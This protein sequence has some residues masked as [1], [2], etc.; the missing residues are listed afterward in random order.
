MLSNN[1]LLTGDDGYNLTKSLRFRGSASAYLNRTPSASNRKTWTWSA[2]VK[3]GTSTFNTLFAAFQPAPR[4]YIAFYNN[5]IY[6][7]GT[8]AG[9]DF[10]ECS[11]TA[12]FRDFS[13]WYHIVFV[14]DTTQATGSNRV[15][16]Y[17]NGVQQTLTFTT[18]PSQN[19]DGAINGAWGHF[20]GAQ[21]SI[22]P[23]MDAYL[24][25]VNFIDG[26]ALTPSSFGE[27]D[28]LTGVWKPKKF[29]GTY[30]TNGFYLPFTDVAT[31]S[32]SNTGLGKDFSGNG[33]YFTTNNIS[34]T[35]GSTYD[36]MTDV[37][38]LTSATTANYCVINPLSPVNTSSIGSSTTVTQG[39]LYVDFA[40]TAYDGFMPA[41]MGTTS[42]KFYYEFKLNATTSSSHMIGIVGSTS[43]FGE[44]VVAVYR[45]ATGIVRV[46]ASTVTTG[47]A[48][49]TAGDVIGVA[50]DATNGTCAWYKNNTLLYTATGLTYPIYIPL[51]YGE[52]GAGRSYSGWANFG[53]Q[54]FV[55]TP[56][57]GFVALNT[58][59]LPTSTIVQGN[60]VMNVN[61]YTG[62]GST[63]SI[64]NAG[65][66]KPDLVWVKSRSSATYNELYDSV[67][68][69]S[70]RLFSNDTAAEAD[71]SPYGVTAFNSNGFTVNDVTSS[72]YGVNESGV[73][74]VGWQWQAGQGSS[75]SN[76]S[77]SITSTV[78]VNATAGFSIATLTTQASGTATFGH[79]L[80]VA[81]SMVICKYRSGSSSWFT[82]HSAISG[83]SYLKL[84][85]TD[86]STSNSVI[87]SASP[88]STV[89]NLGTAWGG[90]GQIV[91]YCWSEIAGFSK[92]GSYTGNGSSDGTFVYL[93]FRPK[94]MMIKRTDTA[95]SWVIMDTTRNPYNA[96][97]LWLQAEGSN[98]ESTLGTPQFDFISNGMKLRG[99]SSTDN[100]SGGTYI[101]MAFAENPFKNALAR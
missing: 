1:L 36:S 83:T 38:T 52:G 9:A 30:G 90:G 34:V 100:A 40:S 58:F 7:Y 94:Y 82:W 43:V 31:T 65:A 77:G 101:Y 23:D 73:S 54:P 18:T 50:F 19:S 32:G 59:N 88:T 75:S 95:D 60:T 69:V 5:Q 24:A 39:N 81:P 8:S 21:A 62:N 22:Y 64:T 4:Q 27:T 28:I 41:T 49:C 96:V 37:P 85:T 12:V 2:W 79:G 14:Y 80:G 33:N 45:W 87:F 74:Y 10:V 68:G 84:E 67:R 76:T 63:Q 6:C 66:T 42:G 17:V 26:Q 46:N 3:R 35:T 86:A 71:F 48:T 55:Y 91:A 11:T 72:G 29:A 47:L 97:N 93:G 70:K 44:S 99:S 15:K 25:E 92:F 56:P 16:V 57:T 20:I 98:T 13:A 61:T 89:V 53:Q 51:L 78:S